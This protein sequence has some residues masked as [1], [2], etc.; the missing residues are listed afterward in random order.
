MSN[1]LIT[2]ATGFVGAAL[3]ERLFKDGHQIYAVGSDL[4]N[5]PP[6][7]KFLPLNLSGF[8]YDVLPNIDVCFHQAANNSTTDKDK[9]NMIRANVTDPI[10]LFFSLAHNKNCKQFIYASSSAIYGKLPI[11]HMEDGKTQPLNPYAE[12]KLQFESLATQFAKDYN[13]KTVGLR[14]TNVFGPG[15]SHKGKRASMIHQLFHT[16]WSGGFPVLFTDGTQKRDW[17]FIDD[18]VEANLKAMEYEGSGVFNVGSGEN[19]TFN[20]IIEVLDLELFADFPPLYM[21]CPFPEAYQDETL[22]DL[23]KI[24]KEL[25]YSPKYGI[26]EGI[27][28]FVRRQL[29]QFGEAQQEESRRLQKCRRLSSN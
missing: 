1:V 26:K 12:S 7:H 13:I 28:E 6:C 10:N 14:Y 18:V 5:K 21:D 8:A 25:G 29:K 9:E 19:I 24:K 27:K 17:V 2:G 15:E 20:E 16:I 3:C 23:T 11:P 4:E 22:A